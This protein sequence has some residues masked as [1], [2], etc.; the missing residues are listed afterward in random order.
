[1]SRPFEATF[2]EELAFLRELGPEMAR[3]HPGLCD[4]L[5]RP[6]TDPDVERLLEGFALVAAR[7]RRRAEQAIPEA[8]EALAE[9]VAPHALWPVAASTVMELVPRPGVVPDRARIARGAAFGSR[10]IEGVRC[11]LRSTT[12][13]DLT[14]IRV[15][16]CSLDRS[17]SREPRLLV[18]VRAPRSALG[19]L[20]A[21]RP[22]RFY[23]HAPLADAS[24]LALAIDRWL[25]GVAARGSDSPTPTA[26]GARLVD[27]EREPHLPWPERSPEGA[28]VLI[29]TAFFPERHLF[30]EVH[31]LER[32]PDALRHDQLEIALRFT[33]EAAS[34][35]PERLAEDALRLHCVPAVNVFPRDAEPIR[36]E[37]DVRDAPLRAA[38][39]SPRAVEVLDV[40]SVVGIAPGTRG[41]RAYDAFSSFDGTP[42]RGRFA[43]RR[44]LSP[45]D[46]R[47]DTFLRV[48]DRATHEA[49][50]LSIEL[51]CT[52]RALASRLRPGDVSE[53]VAGSPAL[54]TFTNLLPLGPSA[55][56]TLAGS[57]LEALVG[58]TA[59]GHRARL[60]PA[61]MRAWWRASAVPASVDLG[62]A[63]WAA[64]LA[65]ALVA[66]HATPFRAARR[67]VIRR[68]VDVALELD[69]GRVPSV[70][71][72]FL[73]A[74]ALDRA[75]A[76]ELPLQA[77][78]RVTVRHVPAGVG[79]SFAARSGL[80]E[81]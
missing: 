57:A 53:A 49:E 24:A 46:G 34:V 67:G 13:V 59:T 32:V 1:M 23:V 74:R 20:Y 14:P 61:A 70:G 25:L 71:E 21:P 29:E 35:L 31:G 64:A 62:R 55:P 15:E 3:A 4:A 22:L 66:V 5:A 65:D 8:V 52:N 11:E 18:R 12:D 79:Y 56:P 80:A 6:G 48:S 60:E 42:G 51:R 10:P 77:E 76:Q 28:R 16:R 9:V 63:R 72:A 38:G 41:R 39:L 58:V 17:S 44:E 37:D 33:P 19:V 47:V 78:Q 7:V 45:L 30:F 75:L 68:G 81:V 43:L 50:T 73:F 54:A 36:W 26:L 69:A 27:P 40:T 2:R